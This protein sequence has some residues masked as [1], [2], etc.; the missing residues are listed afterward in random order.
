MGW[1]ATIETRKI[2]WVSKRGWVDTT[3]VTSEW[4]TDEHATVPDLEE[5]IASTLEAKGAEISGFE[6]YN[7][8]PKDEEHVLSGH[9]TVQDKDRE[10]SAILE[11][12]ATL[13]EV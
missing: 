4:D 12:T 10:E 5:A 7:W 11:V 13:K 9:V 8:P 2:R 1:T 3:D 6:L